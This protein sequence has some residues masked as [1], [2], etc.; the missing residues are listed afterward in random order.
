MCVC[1]SVSVC[2][3]VCVCMC[4][5]VYG[6]VLPTKL[7]SIIVSPIKPTK[8]HQSVTCRNVVTPLNF[9]TIRYMVWHICRIIYRFYTHQYYII[10]STVSTFAFS[11]LSFHITLHMLWASQIVWKC[12]LSICYYT[13]T[14]A[15]P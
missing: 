2:L 13:N 9:C 10:N 11:L 4:V 15:A 3:C 1:V 7:L 8:S 14:Y 6:F 12:H 5:F